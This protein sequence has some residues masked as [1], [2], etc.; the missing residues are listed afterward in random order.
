LRH[1]YLKYLLLI[2]F[3]I[4]CHTPFSEAA[5]DS[6]NEYLDMDI[7]QLMQITITSV[8]K[9]PQNLADAAAAVFVIT[10]D[11]LH[12]SGATSIPEA[13]RMVPGLQVARIDANKWAVTSRGFSGNFANKLLVMIDGR[14][15]YSSSFSGVYW[16]A[17]DTLFD[18]IDRIEVI[19]G[20]GATIW[21]ANAVNGVINIITKKADATQGGIV[22]LAG[23]N[24]DQLIGGLRYGV[25][26]GE[27]I[28]GRTY[29]TYH[30]Q[31]SFERYETD[32]DANDDWDSLRGGFRLDGEYGD[33]NFWTLQGDLYS[34][35]ENQI[36]APFWESENTHCLMVYDDFESSGW[37]ILGRWQKKL[38]QTSSWTVQSYFDRAH[39]DEIFIDQTHQTFDL[40]LQYQTQIGKQNNLIMGLG[41]RY[42]IADVNSTFQVSILPEK[43]SEDLYSGFIQDEIML[44][45]DRLWLTLGVKWE[46][47]DYTGHEIQPSGR[48]L[49]KAT[50]KQTLWVAVSRAVRTPFQF[51]ERGHLIMMVDLSHP[52]FPVVL[53]LDGS[54]AYDSEKVIAYEV[55]Y[56]WLPRLNFSFDLALFYNDYDDLRTT[57]LASQESYTEFVFANQMYGSSYGVELAAD[58]KPIDWLKFQLGYTYIGFD[59]E[60]DADSTSSNLGKI[61][62]ETSPRH[63]VSLQSFIRI[64]NTLQLNLLARY[65]GAL[66]STISYIDKEMSVDEYLAFDA[67]IS[68]QPTK[69]INLMLVGQNLFDSGHLEYVSEFNVPATEIGRSVYAKFS[70]QF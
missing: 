16:D 40:D 29:L 34:N 41:Y 23:G 7:A 54:K 3:S 6:G 44:A 36:I 57:D 63:Q 39:R 20:P 32:K 10:Q 50:D 15:V 33:R 53:S 12:R 68:W 55:G 47:N 49:W 9:K 2:S 13:L 56:R 25:A 8:A 64:N 35:H 59:L 58:W 27:S 62:A 1:P 17:Q 37:N 31:N 21:G 52:S 26:M 60:V 4:Y 42:I 51:E 61:T 43:Q 18:D 70:Y 66:D 65:V 19:R 11:D 69:N 30:K 5:T 45:A 67:N 46:H 22:S 24:Q 28:H 38:S 14:S 48:L